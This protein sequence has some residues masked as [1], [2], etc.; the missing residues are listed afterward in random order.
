[1]VDR[2]VR[3]GLVRRARTV[4]D[5]RVVRLTLTVAGRELVGEVTQRRREEMTR[6][7][8]AIPPHSYTDL[9]EILSA[10]S[11]AASEPQEADWWIAWH[12]ET[13]E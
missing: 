3:K 8:A 1:M 6:L 4:G 2:L 13:D 5:R 9:V 10:I 12:N 7:V 11:E